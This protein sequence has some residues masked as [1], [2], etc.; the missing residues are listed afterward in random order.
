MKN[1]LDRLMAEAGV[2]G[3]LVTGAGQHNPYMVYLT[4]GAHLTKAD[5]IKKRGYPP[6]L[7]HG[8]M[9]RDEAARSGLHT[10]SYSAYPM[11]QL[12][13]ETNDDMFQAIVLRYER[14]LGEAGIIEGVVCLYGQTDL[15]QGYAIFNELQKRMPQITFTGGSQQDIFQQ[16]MATK[17]VD[18]INRIRQMGKI[19]VSVTERLVDF[20]SGQK[21][22]GNRLVNHEGQ[23]ITVGEVKKKINLWLAEAGG[24]NPEGTIFAIGRDAGVP[25][26][27]GSAG[28]YLD[29]GKTIVFDFFPCEPGGGYFYDFTRTWCLGYAPD[30]VQQLYS[31]VFEVYQKVTS[32]L[33]AGEL[34][35]HYQ[36]QTCELFEAMGHPTV[37]TD[38]QTEEGYVHSIGHGLGLH[39]HEKPFPGLGSSEV[40]LTG[41][42]FTIEPGLYYPDR[43][44][45]I[46]LEDSWWITP[47][48]KAEIL[49]EYPKQLI[50]PI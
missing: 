49:V 19:V 9:E 26:S 8:P 48:G 50:I 11:Q 15:G 41:S 28:D 32:Q 40:L 22:K 30:E 36:T 13:A 12:L 6:V 44:M 17:D 5:L 42:V 16:A 24:E 2:E 39:I 47:D 25:H 7:F 27:T 35:S 10:I 20:L 1:D 33:R 23:P 4:G 37:M 45:G 34:F 21:A 18:E 31:Q 3:L 38:A 29:L 43:G 46:R 14:M